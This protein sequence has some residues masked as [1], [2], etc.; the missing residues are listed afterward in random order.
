MIYN[1]TNLLSLCSAIRRDLLKYL[2]FHFRRKS[3]CILKTVTSYVEGIDPKEIIA[4]LEIISIV[5]AQEM[6]VDI[7]QNDGSLFLN[8]GCM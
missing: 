8:I 3:D 1:Y 5:S 7:F 4:L 6:Y 2:I